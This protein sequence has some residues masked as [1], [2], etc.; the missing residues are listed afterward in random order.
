MQTP[1]VIALIV[2]L[3]IRRIKRS[4][5]FQK[6]N[7]TTLIIRMVLFGLVIV[8]ILSFAIIYP[9]ALIPDFIGIAVGL[10]LAYIATNHAQFE[11]RE[12][13]VYFKTHIWVEMA[14]I[15]LFIARM[16]YRIVVVKDIFQDTQTNED[17]QA[18]MNY[19]R[20]PLTG[21]IMFAFCTYYIGYFSFILKEGKAA[22]K[23]NS[24][25]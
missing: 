13:G 22:L 3:L 17:I 4:V 11:K 21:S 10:G 14:V 20:D 24:G 19:M 18:K 5:G 12:N 2:L 16:V 6:F 25:Q 1:V 9:M 7:E 15:G 8:S 23:D